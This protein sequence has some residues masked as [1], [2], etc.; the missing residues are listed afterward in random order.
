MISLFASGLLL[1][2]AGDAP[3]DQKDPRLDELFGRLH[4]V[5]DGKQARLIEGLIWRV[6]LE[7]DSATV[8]LLMGRAV[9][10]MSAERYRESLELL[11]TIVQLAPD[12]AEGWNKRA[13]VRYLIGQDRAAIADVERTLELEPRHFG[14]LS[15]LGLIHKRLENEAAALEAFE[16]A[17][18]VNPHL[19]HAQA[20]I[21][22]LKRKVKG[23][24]I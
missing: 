16:Q 15:G 12:Y 11:D 5:E 20:E 3:A 14:A 21:K 22:R 2:A 9:T 6:W 24:K 1:L 13:T 10:A 18:A 8:D 17:L 4:S 7:T 23:E 19:G